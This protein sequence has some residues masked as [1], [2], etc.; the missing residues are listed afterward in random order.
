MDTSLEKRDFENFLARTTHSQ[1]FPTLWQFPKEFKRNWFKQLDARFMLILS[2]TFVVEV[3]AILFLLSRLKADNKDLDFNSIQKRY[4]HLLLDKFSANAYTDKITPDDTFLYGVPDEVEQ[5]NLLSG[6]AKNIGKNDFV[7][8]SSAAKSR[9]ENKN[10]QSNRG[11][12]SDNRTSNSR[13]GSTPRAVGSVG[14]L[15]YLSDGNNSSSQELQELFAQGDGNNQYLEGSLANVKLDGYVNR[16]GASPSTGA[17]SDNESYFSGLKGSKTSVSTEEVRSSVTPLERV[18]YSTI[19][20]NT[21]LEESSESILNRTGRKASARKAE[22]VTRIVLN[23]NRSIQD[24]YKQALKRKSDLKGKVVVRFAVTPAG[25]VEQVDVISSTIDY[26]P[27]ISCIVNRIRRWNDF[28]ESDISLGTV[29]YR[30]TYV[31]GY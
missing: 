14:L 26:D 27:M 23:H 10:L 11:Q 3:F 15:Q 4:A 16:G 30:Q 8:E 17:E 13:T 31:F 20:K 22:Q 2:L 18:N 7:S 21:E 28:G 19:A 5:A 25:I 12:P 1:D 9:L 24:C 29:S 6:S